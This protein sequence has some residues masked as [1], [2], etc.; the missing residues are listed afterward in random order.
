[1][2]G[3]IITNIQLVVDFV[4]FGTSIPNRE[5]DGQTIQRQL[6]SL[7]SLFIYHQTTDTGIHIGR[8][9]K[10]TLCV[11][12]CVVACETEREKKSTKNELLF[13]LCVRLCYDFRCMC[14]ALRV[15]GQQGFFLVRANVI[16]HTAG[17]QQ[18]GV[19]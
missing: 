15:T 12:V 5:N 19:N 6:S 4:A 13:S 2:I 10:M 17:D 14:V 7:P 3:D 8:A 18:G 16:S 1:M 11:F 9:L